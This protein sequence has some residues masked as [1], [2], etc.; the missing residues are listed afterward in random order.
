[1]KENISLDQLSQSL[2]GDLYYDDSAYHHTIR[3]AYSTDASVYQELPLAV[4]IPRNSGDIKILIQFASANGITIIPR[5]AGTS[6]AGQVV[7]NGIV[8]DISKY[9]NKILELN[10]EEQ[11]VRVQPGVIR[12]DLNHYL[13]PFG[14]MFG[15][16]TSTASRAMIGGM[17]GNNSSG[18]HSIVWGDTRQNLLTANVILDDQSEVVFEALDEASYFKKLIQKDREGAIY[19]ELNAMLTVEEN[20]QAIASGYPKRSITRRNTGYALDMVSDK[21][22]PFNMCRLLAGSEGTLA[23]VT[24]AKLQ[25]LPLPPKEL[26][27]L[28]IHFDDMIACMEGNVIALSHNPEAS[29]LVDKYI[30]DFTVGHPTYQYNRFFIEGDPKALLIVEFRGNTP[31]EVEAKAMALKAALIQKHLGYAYPYITGEQ[32]NLVWDVRKAGLGLIRNLPGDSQPVNLIEDCAVSPEDLPAYVADIQNLLIAEGVH[33]SYYAHAGAGELHIEPFVNLKTESGV[34]T[35]RSILE[36]TTDLVLKYNGSLS[37]EHGDGRL[38]GEFIE[39]VLGG[40]VFKLIEQVKEIFDP[41]GVFNA[42]KIVNTPPMD[43]HLRYDNNKNTTQIKTYFDFSKEESI[44]RLAE[45]CSGSGDCRK[46]EITGGTMCPSFMATRDE[47]DTTRA[48]AN[49]LRQFLTNSTKEN[50]FDHEELKEVMDLCLSCKGCKTECPSSVDVAKMKAEFL[51]HYYDEHGVPFRS[52]VIANFTESQKLGSLVAPLYNF[53]VKNDFLAGLVKRTIGFA[54][55]RSL[56]L[57]AGTTLSQWVRKQ[58]Y[59]TDAKRRVYLFA[60]EFTEYNDAEIGITA[61]KLLTALG[62]EV[63]IPKHIESGRT[64]LSKGL[65]KE[66]KKIA[67]KNITFLKDLITEETPLLGIEPS[68]I[69]TFRDEYLSLV[70]S[71]LYEDASRVAKNA[72]MFDEFLLKEIE[73]GRIQKEQFSTRE[74]TIK[75]HGHCYQ[76]AFHLVETTEKVLSFPQNYQVEV[77]PSGCCGMAGSFGYEKEHYDISMKVAELVLLPTVRNTDSST[78]IAAAGTSCRHQIKDGAARHSYHPVEILYDA[79][80]K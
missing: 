65:V 42:N 48:R 23:I 55:K 17:I 74:K 29:E 13:K 43:T 7:G 33:A 69:I 11:W 64:Y 78:W 70:D 62:Y 54:P 35:F 66:A 6:L 80:I 26:G 38:R 36:K 31:D 15:P 30:M 27:L 61:Y 16:E 37:G 53:V 24:E 4:A 14:F 72:L 71:D 12:D 10:V 21:T 73:A 58:K 52:R 19:R 75:L 79:L 9:F 67:N 8:M 22:A 68:G 41:K 59:K 46:T 60:D 56:P 49:M 51:Q 44:L 2:T 76:K 28:C 3:L 34:K 77:I 32:T 50:R 5:T 25:L 57:V 1:M 40:K 47:K 45:K 20:M 63:I 39:K 18:L